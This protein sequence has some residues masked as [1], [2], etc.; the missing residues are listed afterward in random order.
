M[1][2]RTGIVVLVSL[3]LV[4]A[5]HAKQ[6]RNFRIGDWYAGAYTNDRTGEFSHCAASGKYRSG[7][8]VLFSVHKQWTWEMSFVH[9]DWQLPSGST[10]DIAFNIDDMS[11][12]TARAIAIH[13]Q[14]VRVPLGDTPELFK[15]FQRGRELRVGTA[16]QTFTFNLR[17]TNQV[18]QELLR[19]TAT[20]GKE[21]PTT[22]ANPFSPA[23]K[24][25]RPAQSADPLLYA[26]AATVA[27]NVLSK[28][29]AQGFS[30]LSTE[31][32]AAL[33]S[34]AAWS[35]DDKTLGTLSI[36]PGHSD[37]KD[38]PKIVIARD[39]GL[40]KGSFL[41]G[42]VP[43]DG[44]TPMARIFTTCHESGDKTTSVYYLAVPRK[45]G[46][47]YVFSTQ[48]VGSEAPAKRATE[49][50]RGAVVDL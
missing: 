3:M 12:L 20:A 18:L 47:L 24:G 27:A 40:C 13:P 34:H 22:A 6:I 33:K 8:T 4:T 16:G 50:I 5:S 10:Y 41:S 48:S 36:L 21:S 42:A 25:D 43:E 46:G 31:R 26:E 49:S 45:K 15:R 11:P 38:L 2:V 23:K 1:F 29:G 28:S 17:Q 37:A 14:Q 9:P 32:A 19:C 30:M 35:T 39:A 7:V 44:K